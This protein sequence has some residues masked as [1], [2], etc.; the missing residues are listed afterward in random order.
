MKKRL[1]ALL[2][3]AVMLLSLV[4]MTVFATGTS[5]AIT[6]GTPESA[7]ETNH[8]YITVKTSAAK[9]ETVTITVNPAKG[10]QLK[11]LTVV[12][13]GFVDLGI[14]DAEGKPLYWKETN[15]GA[16]NASDPGDYYM[17]GTTALM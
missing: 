13:T 14:T 12:P 7:K 3:V 11:S 1:L 16:S 2:L 17:W 6:N 9:G 15:L 10:Y 5:Y 4:P 8:G